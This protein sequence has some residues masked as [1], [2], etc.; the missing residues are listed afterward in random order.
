MQLSIAYILQQAGLNQS[1]YASHS[2]KIG[3]ATTTAAAGLPI[4]LITN[5]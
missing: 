2:F 4:W 5:F 1:D 3:A